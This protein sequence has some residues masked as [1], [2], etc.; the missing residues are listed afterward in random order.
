MR[1]ST[2]VES[3]NPGRNRG[4]ARFLLA[5]PPRIKHVA[6][7]RTMYRRTQRRERALMPAHGLF[8]GARLV[9]EGVSPQI[10]GGRHA[11]KRIVGDVLVVEADVYKDGHDLLA[12]RIVYR[13][14]DERQWAYAPMRYDDSRDRWTGSFPLERVGCWRYT[15]EAWP[16]VFGPWRSELT[17]KRAAG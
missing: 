8:A 16:D 9:I 1:N 5:L 11:V 12:A 7:E 2:V 14:A 17:K 13:P 6:G 10:D 4:C 3:F 15:V